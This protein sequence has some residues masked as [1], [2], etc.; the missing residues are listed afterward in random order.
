[1]PRPLPLVEPVPTSQACCAPL[2]EA[3]LAATDAAALASRLKA[4]ADP[5]RLQLLSILLA[6][7]DQEAC[8]CDLTEPLGLSQPTV[9]HHLRR[10]LDAGLVTADRRGAWTFYRAEPDALG[11]LAGVIT[12][13]THAPAR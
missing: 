6:S 9:T 3:P 1:M 5:A 12:P 13:G 7:D 4:L 10:L 8:T 2:T 11:A